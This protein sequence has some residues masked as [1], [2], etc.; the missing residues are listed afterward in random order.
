MWGWLRTSSA[1][2]QGIGA[3]LCSD[4]D[5]A[6][7]LASVDAGLVEAAAT[8]GSGSTY[9]AYSNPVESRWSDQNVDIY[10]YICIYTAYAVW[11]LH[12]DH[13]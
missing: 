9:P 11:K 12:T 1:A 8:A 5:W 3:G 13:L 7:I 10:I 4:E 2:K 6:A